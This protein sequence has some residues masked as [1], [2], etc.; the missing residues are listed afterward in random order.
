MASTSKGGKG[1]LYGVGNASKGTSK[2]VLNTNNP[3]SPDTEISGIVNIPIIR[4]R[5]AVRQ[6]P[7]YTAALMRPVDDYLAAEELDNIQ[8]E[9]E[10]LL[11]NV[12]LRYRVLKLEYD[13]ID[14]DE[15][16]KDKKSK[17]GA[18]GSTGG[19]VEKLP[20]SPVTPLNNG[21]KRKRD[22]N[23]SSRKSKQS[24]TKH[25]KSSMAKNSPIALHTDDSM[26]YNNS[27]KS[28]GLGRD[29]KISLPK[30]DTPNKFWLSVEPYCM[31]LTHEDIR[32][33]DDLLEQ[34]SGPLVPPIPELGPHYTS[35]W[36]TDDLKNIQLNSNLQVNGNF[37]K[38]GQ[39]VVTASQMLKKADNIL[40]ECVTGPLTQRLVSA[41]IEEHILPHTEDMLVE[42]SNGNNENIHLTEQSQTSGDFRSL[43]MLNNCIGIENR[44]KN[45]LIEQGILDLSDF[46][47]NN[48]DQILSEINKLV[49]ELSA[50]A[51]YNSDALKRLH[52]SATQE[53]KRLEVKRKLDLID[54]EILEAYKRTIQNKA[55]RKPLTNE[56]QEEIYRLT[57]EQ[58]T[59][60]D[61]LDRMQENCFIME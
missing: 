29:H 59:L 48:E 15:K 46:P 42:N 14:R 60:S 27:L 58:K 35:T 10:R 22:E 57:N 26:E 51:E 61:Q 28:T 17:H 44:L 50:I 53:I 11:S 40:G 9:L 39:S 18:T 25:Y 54:Q 3:V 41:L 8:L 23:S 38:N 31:P 33:L 47:N 16:I 13:N 43:A 34:Y 12:A 45:E 19:S 6:L 2:V 5:D 52:K 7:S 21:S 1:S 55:K 20:V 4:S 30:N 32:L 37:H 24:N 56:E 49:A 36:A